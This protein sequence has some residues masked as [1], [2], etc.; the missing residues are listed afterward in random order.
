MKTLQYFLTFYLIN[1]C[2]LY[3][4]TETLSCSLFEQ[5]RDDTFQEVIASARKFRKD[6]TLSSEEENMRAK[7]IL[8]N[9][10]QHLIKYDEEHS[11]EKAVRKF[12][13]DHLLNS[14]SIVNANLTGMAGRS[15]DPVFLIKD[16]EDSLCYVVKAFR[17]PRDLS[18]KFLPEISALDLIQQLSMPGVVP[19]TPIAF[20]IYCGQEQEWGLLLE[21][22][23]EG[24]RIDQY[25]HHLGSLELNSEERFA[26]LEF[27]QNVFRRMAESFVFLHAKKSSHPF[28]IPIEH[29][30]KFDK[31]VST[32]L[33]SPFVI[34][35]LEQHFS[36]NEFHQY[37]N[38]IKADAMNSSFFYSYWHGDAHL[39]NMF[40]NPTKDTF[41]FIDSS[42]MHNSISF[43]EEPLQDSMK[44]LVSVEESLRRIA[45]GILNECEVNALLKSFYESYEQY[46]GQL[47]QEIF[48]F[49]RTN[50]KLERL[51]TYSRYI[52][53]ND[54]IKKSQ[55]KTVFDNTV[56]Y[57]KR[58]L[59]HF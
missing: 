55:D 30:D 49:D 52:D 22:A 57:F 19:I 13:S 41:Y 50:K 44:D 23:A 31:K 47:I 3:C 11:L 8:D 56:M 33:E 12:V 35:E 29:L 37:L 14:Y 18:S 54:P 5:S 20:G 28:S 51:K 2:N 21:T 46:S 32:I 43:N 58:I 6:I 36:L 34:S 10:C 53:E 45:I 7:K 26:F 48:L 24:N 42:K 59:F 39:Q 25:I 1:F 4:Q 38:K 17:N 15:Q 9:I 16:K 27:C 40:Y